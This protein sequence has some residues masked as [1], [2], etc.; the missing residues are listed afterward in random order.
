[1]LGNL[2]GTVSSTIIVMLKMAVMNGDL[3]VNLDLAVNIEVE[4]IELTATRKTKH[5]NVK[6]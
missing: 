1:M 5:L 3:Q 2:T 6:K 4:Q